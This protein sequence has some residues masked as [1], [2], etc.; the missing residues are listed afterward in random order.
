[1][2]LPKDAIESHVVAERDLQSQRKLKI[3]EERLKIEI[4]KLK[5][6]EM[7]VEGLKNRIEIFDGLQNTKPVR[8]K[9]SKKPKKGGQA[10]A[11][12]LL[13]DVHCEEKILPSKVNGLN[14]FSL[15][16]CEESIHQVFRRFVML[17]N[18]ER[19]LV[20]IKEMVLWIGG[21]LFT[22]NVPAAESTEVCSLPVMHACR[23]VQERIEGGI[24]FLLDNAGL[25]KIKIVTSVGNHSR[26]TLKRMIATEA[27]HSYEYN[28]YKIMESKIKDPRIE[29]QVGEGYLSY[30]DVEGWVTRWHHGSAMRYYGGIGGI[31]TTI[32]KSIRS[33]DQQIKADFSFS[34]H[35]HQFMFG[36][37]FVSNGS[38]IGYS[39]FS[40]E[41]RAEYEDPSQT[42]CVIDNERGLTVVKKI[43]CRPT[44]GSSRQ[45]SSM[46]K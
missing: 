36:K 5:A 6:S 31:G 42:F 4:A 30:L 11:L 3:T 45:R 1:M 33:W 28:L 19:M 13:S 38:I 8:I 29:W 7:E 22:G 24:Q 41:I 32:T 35:L 10:T 14:E 46:I 39:P 43:F 34:G 20:D 23:W 18:Q 44:M 2:K 15:D 21:D 16:I 12:L 27:E 26:N 37:N 25:D 17:L 9:G 40:I